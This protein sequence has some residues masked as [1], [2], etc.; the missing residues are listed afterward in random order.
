[1]LSMMGMSVSSCPFALSL[2]SS[3]SSSWSTGVRNRR[4]L[5]PGGHASRWV[6]GEGHH[7]NHRRHL[8]EPQGP[9]SRWVEGEGCCVDHRPHRRQRMWSRHRRRMFH[10]HQNIGVR[11]SPSKCRHR[12]RMSRHRHHQRNPQDDRISHRPTCSCM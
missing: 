3:S 11:C 12:S 1:M 7:A 8:L 4:D 5:G 2:P 9:A 6:E 10:H